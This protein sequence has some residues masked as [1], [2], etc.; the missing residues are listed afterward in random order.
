M[1][2]V[3]LMAPCH[4]FIIIVLLEGLPQPNTIA[5]QVDNVLLAAGAVCE[6]PWA[7]RPRGWAIPLPTIDF[8]R[9][10][11]FPGFTCPSWDI[12]FPIPI[13]PGLLLGANG[14]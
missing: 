13:P 12:G 2:S 9:G 1:A 10:V 11:N 5:L 7:T 3:N 14:L 6:T 4:K 8:H